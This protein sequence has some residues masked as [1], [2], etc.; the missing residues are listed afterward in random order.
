MIKVMTD[1][2]F[3]GI[4]SKY[5]DIAHLYT[6]YKNPT[7]F[8]NQGLAELIY[9]LRKG[10]NERIISRHQCVWMVKV[11]LAIYTIYGAV[12]I[13]DFELISPWKKFCIH[14]NNIDIR[15]E[16]IWIV[17]HDNS[18]WEDLPCSSTS[19][20]HTNDWPEVFVS[21]VL[22]FSQECI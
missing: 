19:S 12:Y 18:L 15:F 4:F 11:Q 16:R 20:F 8:T 1:T 21:W 3:A 5:L 2:S 17:M 13:H 6:S 22:H 9:I 7:F 14:K 10:S